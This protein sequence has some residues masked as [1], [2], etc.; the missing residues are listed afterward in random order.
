[1]EADET[2]AVSDEDNRPVVKEDGDSD[3]CSI[4]GDELEVKSW[5]DGEIK[6]AEISNSD[7]CPMAEDEVE[8]GEERHEEEEEEDIK[9][10][11]EEDYASGH[12][13]FDENCNLM[14][15]GEVEP[16]EKEDCK[17]CD[18]DSDDSDADDVTIEM[19]DCDSEEN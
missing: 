18:S 13:N 7:E 6:K 9:P 10:N 3:D 5:K 11:I 14:E 15:E 17:D 4:L 12:I 19:V 16:V 2:K 1:M 8:E